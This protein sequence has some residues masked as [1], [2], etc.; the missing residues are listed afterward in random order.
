MNGIKELRL[1]NINLK[2][3]ANNLFSNRVNNKNHNKIICESE[4]HKTSQVT[5]HMTMKRVYLL[6]VK[7]HMEESKKNGD[8]KKEM[9]S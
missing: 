1:L 2:V 7:V 4:L 6:A 8:Y 3:I 9:Q 5:K